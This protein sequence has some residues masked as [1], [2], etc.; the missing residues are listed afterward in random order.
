M[1][2]QSR[3]VVMIK[4]GK[5]LYRGNSRLLA[6]TVWLINRR[7]KAIAYDCGPWVVEPAYWIS[8]QSNRDSHD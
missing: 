7:H 1:G 4:G 8:V 5:N 3:Y 6:W 2:K